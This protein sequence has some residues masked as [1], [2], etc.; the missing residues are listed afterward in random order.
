MRKT[1]TVCRRCG[2]GTNNFVALVAG[3]FCAGCVNVMRG[4]LMRLAG[5]DRMGSLTWEDLPSAAAIRK[6]LREFCE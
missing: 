5:L 4:L 6:E 2:S 3:D 1:H